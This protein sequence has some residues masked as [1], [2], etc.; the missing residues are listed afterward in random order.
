MNGN[1]KTIQVEER[2]FLIR[3]MNAKC[4]LKLAKT[5]LAKALPAFSMFFEEKKQKQIE[6][7]KENELFLAIQNCLDTLEDKDLDKVIDT[8][9]QH[10]SEILPAG[11]AN[12][13]NIDGTYGVTGV[14]TDVILT[15]RLVTEVLVFNYEGFFDVSL[16]RSKFSPVVDMLQQNVKM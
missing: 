13:L 6:I 10:C 8:S 14:D 1:T 9:L 12:V 7:V 15:L 2:T 4:S 11:T 5:I 16:W 3:K